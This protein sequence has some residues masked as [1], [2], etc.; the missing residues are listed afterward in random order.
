MGGYVRE[1][2]AKEGEETLSLMLLMRLLLQ[3][4]LYIVL[5]LYCFQLCI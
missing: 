5:C 4:L 3:S 1:N 2:R